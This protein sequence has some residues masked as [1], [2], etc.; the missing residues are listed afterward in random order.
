MNQLLEDEID[1]LV[2][3]YSFLGSKELFRTELELL[4]TLAEREQIKK[5]LE[6][7]NKPAQ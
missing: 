2:N 1:R 5:C 7:L 4:V 3:K 6:S